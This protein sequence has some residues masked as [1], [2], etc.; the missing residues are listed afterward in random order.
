MKPKLK[1]CGIKVNPKEVASLQPDYMGYIFFDGSPRNYDLDTPKP[2]E[3]I[4]KVGVFVNSSASKIL[5]K[6]QQFDLDVV[7]LHGEESVDF[8]K[9][10]SAVIKENSAQ[11][12]KKKIEIWKVFSIAD[13]FDFSTITCYEEL[14]DKFL[15]DTKGPEKGGNGYA[16]DWDVL[17]QYTSKKPFILS[18]GIGIDGIEQLR[19]ILKT[20]LP[21][22][23]IDVNSRFESKPGLKE[24]PKL[25]QFIDQL[26]A[27]H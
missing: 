17:N 2:I 16:F 10:L 7:Q 12:P 19:Q 22:Y 8:C 1:I 25:K 23:A 4:K 5:D 3:K 15:F 26:Y 9:E 21:I 6:V 18:G 24:I 14:V 11:L 13:S 27:E 20:D